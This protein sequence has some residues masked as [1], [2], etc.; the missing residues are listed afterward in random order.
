MRTTDWSEERIGP[1]SLLDVKRKT[2]N[3]FRPRNA[4]P[5]VSPPDDRAFKKITKKLPA[6]NNLR[7]ARG[8]ERGIYLRGGAATDRLD[9]GAILIVHCST[10]KPVSRKH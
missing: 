4:K 3:L 5:S 7:R 9:M 1:R 8:C 10:R 2:M 6:I